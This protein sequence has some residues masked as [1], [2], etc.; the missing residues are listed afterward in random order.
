MAA[1][2]LRCLLVLLALAACSEPA[3]TPRPSPRN[4]ASPI[5]VAPS[6]ATEAVVGCR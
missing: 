4:P 5:A 2:R 3:D 1:C 6:E